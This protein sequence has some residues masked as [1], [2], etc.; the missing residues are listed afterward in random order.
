MRVSI[1]I[2]G[3]NFYFGLKKIY[4]DKK[5]LS[6]FDFEKFCNFLA[7]SDNIVDIFYYNAPLDYSRDFKKYGKQQKFFWK[8]GKIP[9][10]NLILCKLLKRRIIGTDKYYYVLKEDDIHMAVDLVKGAFNNRYDKAIIVSGDGDFVPAVKAAQEKDKIILNAC[11]K[12]SASTNL[13]KNCDGLIKLN[14]RI[15]EEFLE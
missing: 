3:N 5:N 14:S 6:D 9:K 7:G 11:F 12:K 2:D 4:E 8:L 15:L 1:F 13:K 10:F